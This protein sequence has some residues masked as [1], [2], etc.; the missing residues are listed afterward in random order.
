KGLNLTEG[1][2]LHI[3]GDNDKGKAVRLLADLYRQHFSEIVSIALGDSANDY[4]MLTAVDIP[5]VIMRPD[6]SYHP[7]LKG[8]KNA[9]KSPEPG[10]RG[11]Q[12]TIKRV[13]KM[14]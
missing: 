6:H 9:I 4:E 11:W 13:L 5:V 2:F 10:P 14:L 7:L 12:E 8:I 1:R 3:T